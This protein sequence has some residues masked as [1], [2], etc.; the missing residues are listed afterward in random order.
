[1]AR[2]LLG[3]RHPLLLRHRRGAALR[4]A[5]LVLLAGVP[6][7]FRLD[8]GR[9]INPDARI[10]AANLSAPQARKNR[11]PPV[12]AVGAPA[13]FIVSLA[14]LLGAGG[15]A[16]WTAWLATLRARDDERAARTERLAETTTEH[17]NPL[18]LC[19]AIEA[20]LPGDSVIVA[21]GGDFV[22]TA[23]YIVSP[24]GPLSWLRPRAVRPPR[25]RRRLRAGRQ[26]VSSAR[27]GLAPLR[28]R[29]GRIQPRRV[30]HVRAPRPGRHRGGGK[31][32]RLEPDRSG[33]GGA[34]A[35]RRRH[36]APPHG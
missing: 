16:R 34:V 10:V 24:R 6:C 20:V 5:D 1:M 15:S 9:S 33:A 2:G 7:D 25:R 4:A 26:A 35:G 21:D 18:D 27:G 11:R 32:R 31:R 19:R 12:A 17:V 36:G 13:R 22:G 8:Y 14:P 28:R 23:A 3:Q 29:L 30:R